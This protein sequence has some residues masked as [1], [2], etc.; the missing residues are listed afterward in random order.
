LKASVTDDVD[1]LEYWDVH[2]G[3]YRTAQIVD[4]QLQSCI[5]VT[6]DGSLPESAWL[7]SLFGKAGLTRQ[8]RY[9]LLSGL[10]PQGEEDTGRTICSCFHIGEKT[11]QQAVK[12]QGLSSVSA[13]GRYVKAGTGCGSCLPELKIILEN[14]A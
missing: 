8:E 2:R 11:I 12:I 7:R 14:S 9:S 10:P 1:W 13:I 3:N 6:K 5:F 4:Q